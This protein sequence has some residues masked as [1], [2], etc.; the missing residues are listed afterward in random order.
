MLDCCQVATPFII[1]KRL[2]KESAEARILIIILG[3]KLKEY[4]VQCIHYEV[5]I[6]IF[7]IG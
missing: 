6:L 4:P 5:W 7:N 1:T 3:L 2:T